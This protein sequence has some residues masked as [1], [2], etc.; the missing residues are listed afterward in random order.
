MVH[1]ETAIDEAAEVLCRVFT[2]EQD[3]KP[4]GVACRDTPTSRTA[5]TRLW[6]RGRTHAAVR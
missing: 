1:S 3:D 5:S 2:A 4:G 6:S